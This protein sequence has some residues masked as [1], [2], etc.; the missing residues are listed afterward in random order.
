[1]FTLGTMLREWI[2][3]RPHKGM[4]LVERAA[5]VRKINDVTSEHNMCEVLDMLMAGNTAHVLQLLGGYPL[6]EHG[7]EP[8]A[9][10]ACSLRKDAHFFRVVALVLDAAADVLDPKAVEP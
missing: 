5:V 9:R 3:D 7:N 4:S 10:E 2:E 8:E 6:C 1:M